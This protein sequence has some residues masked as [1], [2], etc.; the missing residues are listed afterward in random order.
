MGVVEIARSEQSGSISPAV[1]VVLRQ[2]G[3]MLYGCDGG[4]PV[5]LGVPELNLLQRLARAPG[6]PLEDLVTEEAALARLEPERLEAFVAQLRRRGLV[7]PAGDTHRTAVPAAT[8]RPFDATV[9][10]DD[11]EQL[12]A[13]TP[14]VFRLT[15]LGFELIDHDGQLIE[16]LDASELVASSEFRTAATAPVAFDRHRVGAGA[17]ALDEAQFGALVSRL[18]A[19]GVL[20]R[21]DRHHL[22]GRENN[23]AREIFVFYNRISAE[24]SSACAAQQA[25][26]ANASPAVTTRV[27]I[28][29]IDDRA[30]PLPLALGMILATVMAHENG[31]LRDHYELVPDW[32][33]RRDRL[34]ARARRPGIFL[35]SNYIWSHGH[36][37][38]YSEMVKRASPFNVTVHGGPDTPKYE[39][40]VETYFHENP[41]VD[42]AVH[43]EGEV[44]TAELLEALI[45]AVG[46]GPPDLS[47]LRDVPG[48]SYRDGDAVVRTAK[49]DRLT[50]LDAIPSPFLTGLFDVHARAGASMAILETNR[51]CPYGCTFCDWG[52]ATLSR[53]R[54]F[55]L[56]RVFAELEW[57][58]QHGFSRLFLAD[59]NFGILERD[60]QIAEKV[61]ELKSV[62]GYPTLFSTN[63]AKNTTKHLRQ[64]VG[65]L[66]D[67]GILNQGLLS[68]QSMDGETLKTV[69]RSNIKLAKYEELAREF[70][71]AELPLFVDLMMG[72]PGATSASFRQDLQSC[73]DREV[74]AKVYPT[75]LLVNSPMNEPGYREVNQIETSAPLGG[76]VR[77]S[78]NPDGTTRRALVVATST[79]TR[80]D[81][82]QML[83][84]RHAFLVSENFGVLRQVSRYVRQET[85]VSEVDFYERLRLDARGNPHRWPALAF[86]FQVVPLLGVAPVSW[87]LLIDEIRDYLVNEMDVSDDDALD[88]VLRVQHALLPARDRKFPL[89]LELPH[90]YAAWHR[91]M[92][93][94]RDAGD[95]DWETRVP[96]L[97]SFPAGTFTVEDPFD[98][99]GRAL[100]AA[101]DENLHASWEL[102]SPVARAVSHE[103][104]WDAEAV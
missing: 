68:L 96:P 13:M 74:T 7:G 10:L 24:A 29:P 75:E 69:K 61:A 88:T 21:F 9:D 34:P 39:G 59:A 84:L 20:S 94:T 64:I 60:V 78:R 100:G 56:D 79:F 62:Y 38:T 46:D 82:E 72:L 28:V 36:N 26:A 57:C 53:I 80:A 35:F 30:N 19:H 47:R 22:G 8:Q 83:Q 91:S 27:P 104:Q 18:R 6:A 4:D 97:R 12:F 92:V 81:Y 3:L 50:E 48:L 95:Y 2:A 43:G 14:L 51:G 90:D 40:D 99:C 54:Q 85:G 42:I 71:K 23:V 17:A 77:T 41:H 102:A 73:I 98:V 66:G 87:Q 52:S 37:L 67:A 65:T 55:D 33:T 58:A 5:E 63:Y 101:I 44:T 76:L 86:T 93:D 25:A 32:I 45:G 49:R 16:R 89:T 15:P 11:G 103:H 70:R 1:A 31:L